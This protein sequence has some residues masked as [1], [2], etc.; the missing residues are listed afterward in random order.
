MNICFEV[1]GNVLD[2]FGSYLSNQLQYTVV[3]K[4][5]LIKEK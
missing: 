2:L 1:R 3:S 4:K 5:S